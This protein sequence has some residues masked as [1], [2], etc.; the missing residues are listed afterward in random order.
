MPI[1]RQIDQALV[2]W[3]DSPMR[4]PLMVRGARQV[5][6]TYVIETFAKTHFESRLTV[7]FEFQ[8]QFKDCFSSLEPIEIINK[9]E[10]LA[11]QTIS[12]G[13][14]LLFLDEIQEC[15]EAIQALRYFKE[16]M[17]ELHVV[18]AGSLL[19]FTLRETG[20]RMPVGRIEFLYMY[21]VRFDEF[22]LALDEVP[23][24]DFLQ[25][26][27][28]STAIP[29]AIHEK[30]LRLVRLYMTIGGMPAVINTY[31]ATKNISECQRMQA[32]LLNTFRNDFGKY[33]P[34]I[35]HDLCMAMFNKAAHLVAKQ[36][37]YVDVDPDQ[38]SREL[39]PVLSAL[40]AAGLYQPI[41]FASAN[42][43]PLNA[44]MNPKAFKLLF[45]DIGLV[46]SMGNLQQA[47]VLDEDLM[48]IHQGA[49]V[50]QFVG[51]QLLAYQPY[52]T[53]GELFYWKRDKKG[54]LAEI[55]YLYPYAAHIYPIEVKAGKTGRLKSM[56]LYLQEHKNTPF[57]IKISQQ[58]L[59]FDGTVL[60]IPLYMLPFLER[61][62]NS[63]KEII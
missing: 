7:N 57:G 41:Y 45:L 43:L 26:C 31:L 15:P 8:P 52:Y 29:T 6:K 36:F 17:P 60:S 28:S 2:A 35:N 11:G 20:F 38:T 25:K 62:I 4:M 12:P 53:A 47:L 13:K 32:Q 18:T 49:L 30:A 34:K 9:L 54:S 19:E 14:T 61:L 48:L 58:P 44:T 3:K 42:G 63:D 27:T 21:P 16:Q 59:G 33:K 46:K 23:L 22:L 51:Q 40:I 24:Y 5:G 55:D 10:V 50:E 39:K 56:H 1:Y 37:K